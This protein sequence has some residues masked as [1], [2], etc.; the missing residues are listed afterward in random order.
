MHDAT[1][2]CFLVN[3]RICMRSVVEWFSVVIILGCETMPS[4]NGIML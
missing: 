1:L 2:M 3:G 4:W